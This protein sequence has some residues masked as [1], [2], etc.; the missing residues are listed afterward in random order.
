MTTVQHRGAGTRYERTPVVLTNRGRA[1]VYGLLVTLALLLGMMMPNINTWATCDTV[2]E[3]TPGITQT[4]WD[5][6]RDV[7]GWKGNPEDGMERLYSPG[8]F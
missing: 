1:V 4:M 5:N 3:S 7:Q 6:L 8:C 2:D